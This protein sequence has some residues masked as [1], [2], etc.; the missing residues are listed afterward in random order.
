MKV[1]GLLICLIIPS[2]TLGQDKIKVRLMFNE[3]VH[4]SIIKINVNKYEKQLSFKQNSIIIF[5]NE[6][7]NKMGFISVYDT[8]NKELLI[9]LPIF[10]DVKLSQVKVKEFPIIYS[11]VEG[12]VEY[13]PAY[14]NML[15]LATQTNLSKAFDNYGIKGDGYVYL[16]SEGSTQ[17]LKDNLLLMKQHLSNPFTLYYLDDELEKNQARIGE[18]RL[19]L[20]SKIL[21][22]LSDSLK[23][24]A[25]GKQLI[26][27]FSVF[28]K[29]YLTS[30]I[31]KDAPVFQI[32]DFYGKEYTKESFLNRP[33]IIAF[34]ATW[35][36]PC[37]VH[38]PRLKDIYEKYHK[39]GL[40]VLYVNLHDEKEEWQN[41]IADFDMK[42]INVSE[43]TKMNTSKIAASYNV[44]ALPNYIVVDRQGKMIY[45]D[46]QMGDGSFEKLEEYVQKVVE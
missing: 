44:V 34:S 12:T 28:K 1:L 41:M 9:Q 5:P 30:L 21:E 22:G 18:E 10:V 23:S 36:I 31:G 42:W 46:S 6:T 39:K 19:Y 25:I 2:L 8:L 26:E 24:T 35:C 45:N 11:K 38:L 7:L 15:N 4:H 20:F 13:T 43:L 3:I 29:N 27:K 16:S 17:L 40:E 14:T 32:S 37:K 33:Y